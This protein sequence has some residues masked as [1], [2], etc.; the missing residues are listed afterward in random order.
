[1]DVHTPQ[2]RSFNMSRIRGKDTKPEILLR[3]LLWSNGFRYRLN[4]KDLPGKPDIAFPGLRK[5][6]FVHGCFWHRHS[7]KNGKNSPATNAAFWRSKFE[8]NIKRDRD[9]R[10]ALRKIGWNVLIVWECQTTYHN[11]QRLIKKLC[12]YLKETQTII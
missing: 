8:R 1:M 12:K 3:K 9:V 6:I 5:V 2:K 4:R 7:C 10:K 11:K